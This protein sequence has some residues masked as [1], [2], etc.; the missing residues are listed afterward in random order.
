MDPRGLQSMGLQSRTRLKRLNAAGKWGIKEHHTRFLSPGELNVLPVAASVTGGRLGLRSQEGRRKGGTTCMGG[1]GG[2]HP[3]S[4]PERLGFR[5]MSW[6]GRVG[7]SVTPLRPANTPVPP[8]QAS[9]QA[10][11]R[12]SLLAEP[13]PRRRAAGTRLG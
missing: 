11:C 1:W 5:G 8:P 6:K 4:F 10:G 13:G 9:W 12:Q 3:L 7:L 2:G